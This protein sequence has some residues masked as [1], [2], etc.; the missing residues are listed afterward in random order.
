MYIFV[1]YTLIEIMF[2]VFDVTCTIK[3]SMNL[4]IL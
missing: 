2:G 3:M 1:S 4:R